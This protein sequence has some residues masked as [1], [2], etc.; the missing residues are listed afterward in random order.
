M[1]VFTNI[2]KFVF[3]FFVDGEV[4]ILSVAIRFVTTNKTPKPIFFFNH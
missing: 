3:H 2:L 4:D 1:L